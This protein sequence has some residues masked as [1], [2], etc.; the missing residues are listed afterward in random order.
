M[1]FAKEPANLEKYL[2]EDEIN[3][4]TSKTQDEYQN[5]P[6]NDDLIDDLCYHWDDVVNSRQVQSDIHF[7]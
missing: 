3:D 6:I 1:T 4:Q 2:S 7:A 5:N